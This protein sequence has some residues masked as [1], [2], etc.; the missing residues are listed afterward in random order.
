MKNLALASLFVAAGTTLAHATWSIV[1]VDSRTGEIGIA[2]ATCLTNF[3]LQA[4]SPVVV[5]GRGAAAAQSSVDTTG[6]NRT[7][8][9]DRLSAGV[10]PSE[11]LAELA[12]VDGGHETRQYGIVGLPGAG[13]T[14]TGLEDGQWAGGVSGSFSYTYAGQSGTITYA[15]QGNVLTGQPVIAAALQA[16][17]QTNA[18]LPGRLMAGME[19][20]K[21]LGG[22]GRCS[23]ASGGPTGCGSPPPSFVRTANCGYFI[24][25]RTGDSDV[26]AFSLATACNTQP[27][28]E[29][30]DGDGMKELLVPDSSSPSGAAFRVFGN[31]ALP[32][33]TMPAFGDSTSY[34]C[35]ANPTC[36]ATGDFSR[37]GKPDVVVGGGSTVAGAAGAITLYRTGASGRLE[38]RQDIATSRRVQS[39]VLADIDGVNGVDLVFSTSTQVLVA[40]NNGTGGYAAPVALGNPVTPSGLAVADL[41]GDGALDVIIGAGFNGVRYYTGRGDGTFNAMTTISLTNAAR[42]V[43]V[44]DFNRDGRKDIAV[45]M[46]SSSGSLSILQNTGTGFT[47]AQTISLS[48]V[49]SSLCLADL[50][51]DG[52]Q[53]LACYDSSFRLV[54]IPAASNGAFA[55]SQRVTVGSAAGSLLVA[56]LNGDGVPEAVSTTGSTLILGNARGT[57]INPVGF[58]AGKY[59]LDINIAN[60]SATAVDPV[61]Q[62]RSSFDAIRALLVGLPDAS[63]SRVTLSTGSTNLTRGKKAQMIVELRDHRGLPA[64]VPPSSLLVSVEGSGQR[65]TSNAAPVSLGGGRYGIEVTGVQPGTDRFRIVA[66]TSR[67]PVTV[68]PSPAV[69]VSPGLPQGVAR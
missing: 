53:D 3:D 12:L 27:A 33:S 68:M 6:Q 60:Q 13:I 45:L 51:G 65:A 5:V 28:A 1:L 26:G 32:G 54:T 18:D 34:P 41:N 25:S 20:A 9:R 30:L 10:L 64:T 31:T 8:I 24:I 29:D 23:C 17:M 2:S 37:D 39:V 55:V 57:Y 47:A 52:A 22:D 11:I 59:F 40:L 16:V 14:F 58:A 50:D 67:G 48:A 15:I 19:A 42:G 66:V 7:L 44:H 56:D 46:N 38:A 35:V 61:I 4:N 49:G 62:M 63:C 21:T 36:I 69:T 43:V